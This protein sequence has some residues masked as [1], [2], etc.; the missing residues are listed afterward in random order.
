MGVN[1][2]VS[3]ITPEELGLWYY[4]P[5]ALLGL[6][7]HFLKVRIKGESFAEVKTYFTTHVKSTFAAV[8]TVIL[9]L[10]VLEN[11]GQLN[12]AAAIMAGYATDGMWRKNLSPIC[13]DEPDPL[14]EEPSR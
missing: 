8:L 12:E 11:L 3:Y 13:P 4:A 2:V 7:L 10:V 6:T 9:L 14:D 5:M 1:T